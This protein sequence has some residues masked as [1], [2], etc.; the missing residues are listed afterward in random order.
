MTIN[1]CIHTAGSYMLGAIRARQTT[2]ILDVHAPIRHLCNSRFKK[3]L[4]ERVIIKLGK[5]GNIHNELLPTNASDAVS[6]AATDKA[7]AGCR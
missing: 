2:S 6:K 5:E 4:I 3:K 7:K 1:C